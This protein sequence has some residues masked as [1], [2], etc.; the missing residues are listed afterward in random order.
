MGTEAGD[1]LRHLRSDG[2]HH[3]GHRQLEQAGLQRR[4]PEDQLEVLGHEEERAEHGEERQGHAARGDAEAAVAEQTE[5]EHRVASPVL[6]HGEQHEGDRGQ[7][8]RAER[9]ARGPALVG[10]LDDRVHERHEP[11]DAEQGAQEVEGLLV[12]VLRAGYEGSAQDEGGDDHGHV[13]EEHRAPVEVLEQEARRHRAD[14]GAAT[15]DAGPHGD[16][17][18]PLVGGEDVGE[19]RQRRGHHEGRGDAHD[20]PGGDDHP[21]G[22]GRGGEDG[23]AEEDDE[24]GL[25]GALAAEAVAEGAGGE[26]EPGEHER[27]GVDHPLQRAGAGV[28]LARQGGQR[29][30]EAGVADD[31]DHQA[32]AEHGE[33]GPAPLVHRRLD[34]VVGVG[35]HAALVFVVFG[36]IPS[37][38]YDVGAE[39]YDPPSAGPPAFPS[40]FL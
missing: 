31:D 28:Q 32:G 22:V 10:A 25:E 21:G 26:Q 11:D 23:A 24:A 38:R 15:R 27:V 17:L 29:H 2:H 8:E 7:G 3:E 6:P 36:C 5:V 13:H 40:I 18:G 1:D 9:L 39:C 34:L 16:G 37:F 35:V 20:R 12:G 33:D 30:V 14:G 4:V 19:D